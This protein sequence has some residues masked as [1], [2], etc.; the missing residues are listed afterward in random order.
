MFY[1]QALQS[2]IS[3]Y[4]ECIEK[5]NDLFGHIM[6]YQLHLVDEVKFLIRIL[7]MGYPDQ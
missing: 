4:M 6:K 3:K 2:V 1:F 7:Y 5:E